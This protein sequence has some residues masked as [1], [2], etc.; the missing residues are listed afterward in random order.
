[1]KKILSIA[2]LIAC[3][4]G[5][6][7]IVNVSATT[8][9]QLQN[10]DIKKEGSNGS[11]TLTLINSTSENL[12]IQSGEKVILNLAGHTLNNTT[13]SG[14]FTVDY[15]TIKIAKGG[16]LTIKGDGSIIR[17]NKCD[18]SELKQAIIDNYG[19]LNL[20]SGFISPQGAA[21]YG[22][23]NHT[24]STLNMTGGRV[25]TM[26][27]KTYGLW[28]EGTANISGGRFDQNNYPGNS[29]YAAQPAVVNSPSGNLNISGGE[30]IN[31]TGHEIPTV[32][33][34]SGSETTITGGKFEYQ[35]PKTHVSK[36]QNIS[37]YLPTGYTMDKYGNVIKP[38]N[39]NEPS[40][41]EKED[42][43]NNV[44]ENNNEK[45]PNTSDSIYSWI[46]IIVAS[47]IGLTYIIK[48]KIF[49]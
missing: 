2:L 12:E 21:N 24:G 16:T 38:A 6:G 33:P 31:L 47:I 18:G 26:N 45:N 43:Q 40:T 34:I 9:D 29:D 23:Y 4:F 5:F 41:T 3:V 22:I 8:L 49:N 1:M 14:K 46:S 20:E 36:S 17:T 48:K 7:N 35:D 28:N 32:A 13:T 25:S 30:F 19:T 27:D 15:P 44:E 10:N 11:Y 39:E 42:T 37:Q